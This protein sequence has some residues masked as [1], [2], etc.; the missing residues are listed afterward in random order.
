MNMAE[1]QAIVPVG[2]IEQS[3]LLVGG[4]KVILD[5]DLSRLYG[6]TT[7]AL[8]Q[9]VKRNIE[10]FPGDFMIRL[11]R[12]EAASLRSQFV[13][14]NGQ[15]QDRYRKDRQ[16]STHA[17]LRGYETHLPAPEVTWKRSTG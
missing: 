12:E 14:S 7:R 10:R 15:P 6:V 13:I 11:T 1:E 2:Q 8:N 4:Q 16:G 9:A 17:G 5:A 3:I